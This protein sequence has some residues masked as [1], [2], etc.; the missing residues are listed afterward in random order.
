MNRL[1]KTFALSLMALAV[2]SCS[3][4]PTV[5]IEYGDDASNRVKF[6]AG[7]LRTALELS[8]IHI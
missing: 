6:A 5:A 7:H 2:W 8:L 3:S 4:R 1:I